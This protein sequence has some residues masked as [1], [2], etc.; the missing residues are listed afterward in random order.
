M[1]LK[2]KI[3]GH[4]WNYIN[5]EHRKCKRCL[6][7]QFSHPHYVNEGGERS[8]YGYIWNDKNEDSEFNSN[9]FYS[10]LDL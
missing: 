5:K 8:L 2:C 1:N 6:I 3:L 7:E 9:P 10:G 4:K